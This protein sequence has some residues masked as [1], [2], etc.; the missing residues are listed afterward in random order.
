ILAVPL[1]TA[2]STATPTPTSVPYADF[3]AAPL[4]GPAPLT[5]EFHNTS[6]CQVVT[7]AWDYGD[8]NQGTSCEAYHSHTYTDPGSY[9]VSLAIFRPSGSSNTETKP[10]YIQV[11]SPSP[12]PTPTPT[13]A[14][15]VIPSATPTATITETLT[16]T[17]TRTAEST[18]RA[19]LTYLPLLVRNELTPS[20]PSEPEWDPRLDPL[21]VTYQPA[22]DCSQGCWRLKSARYED[23]TESNGNHNIYVRLFIVNGT[24][25]AGRPW[26]TAWPDGNE[27]I[28]SK[29]APEWADF[30]IYAWYYFEQGPGPYWSYA[31]DDETRSDSVH[32]MGLPVRQHVNFRLTWR[33]VE[34]PPTPTP[35]PTMTPTSTPTRTPT[36]TPTPEPTNT[37]TATPT[38]TKTPK[39]TKTP[40]RTPTEAATA[41]PTNTA[42]ATAT[43]TT[44]RN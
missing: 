42:T 4:D 39:P 32:G 13:P 10:D 43:S 36:V 44:N 16:A 23:P 12:S 8:G 25:V 26:H 5:A 9:T 29:P 22:E 3:E 27:R 15:T 37:A 21:H 18:A 11:S 1:T 40:T 31:G 7:C 33:W 34:P 2:T 19:H 6:C 30:P 17:P 20:D 41:T 35:T 28:Q 14:S 24:Q 38:A